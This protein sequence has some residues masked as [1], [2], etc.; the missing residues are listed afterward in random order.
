[1]V[2]C[3]DPETFNMLLYVCIVRCLVIIYGIPFI[4][5]SLFL[6]IRQ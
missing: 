2:V 5:T 4:F 1:M 3:T 6:R